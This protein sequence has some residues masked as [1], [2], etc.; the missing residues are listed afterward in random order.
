M[1]LYSFRFA[2]Q[3]VSLTNNANY[4]KNINS[5]H[6]L[7]GSLWH[8]EFGRSYCIVGLVPEPVT[9]KHGKIA[10]S[11]ASVLL[12]AGVFNDLVVIINSISLFSCEACFV[13]QAL[14]HVVSQTGKTDIKTVPLLL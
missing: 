1:S 10:A 11:D 3:R 7:N 5:K 4:E 12:Q 6:L 8:V 9:R 14:V 2:C 13:M